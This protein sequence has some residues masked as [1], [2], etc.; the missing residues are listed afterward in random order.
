MPTSDP[1]Q[2]A[3]E[4]GFEPEIIELQDSD[5]AASAELWHLCGL[6]M[7]YND[8]VED[9]LRALHGSSSTVL[10]IRSP[11]G[12]SDTGSAILATVMVGAEGHRGWMYYVA[13]HPDLR[14]RGIGSRLVR[15]AEQWLAEHDIPK[16][17]LM[18]RATNMEAQEFY[19][20]LGYEQSTVTVMQRWL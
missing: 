12:H 7:P 18:V 20:S 17:M 19:R 16:A 10:G 3:G 2:A 5:A 4:H 8:P 9:Y 1:T 13:V 14:Y 6:T 11:A 15:A